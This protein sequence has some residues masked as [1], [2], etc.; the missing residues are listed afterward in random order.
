MQQPI[1]PSCCLFSL[2]FL[3]GILAM[4]SG[5]GRVGT[6]AV[7]GGAFKVSR[8]PSKERAAHKARRSIE[9]IFSKGCVDTGLSG[10]SDV[11]GTKKKLLL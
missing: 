7:N 6:E 9:R 5:T 1:S 3:W 4:V 2:H 10:Y 11:L 8:D